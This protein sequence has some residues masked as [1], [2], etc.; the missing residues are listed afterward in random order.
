[1]ACGSLNYINYSSYSQTVNFTMGSS[2]TVEFTGKFS[3][4]VTIAFIAVP[5]AIIC[6]GVGLFLF[7]SHR[8]T[9]YVKKHDKS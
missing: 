3:S 2:D 5:I 7:I 9:A 8:K 4:G 1:M 6:V